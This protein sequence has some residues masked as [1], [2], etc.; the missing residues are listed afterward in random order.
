MCITNFYSTFFKLFFDQ[1]ST[2]VFASWILDPMLLHDLEISDLNTLARIDVS[3][4]DKN[5]IKKLLRIILIY[6]SFASSNMT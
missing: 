5:L 6:N 2:F 4:K 1:A 3:G